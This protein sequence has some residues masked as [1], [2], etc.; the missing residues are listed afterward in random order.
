MTKRCP[1]PVVGKQVQIIN[2]PPPCLTSVCVDMQ[3]LVCSKCSPVCLGQKA[4]LWSHLSSRHS[5]EDCS[6]AL[7]SMLQTSKLPKQLQR[8]QWLVTN[9]HLI[10]STKLLLTLLISMEA[11]MMFFTGLHRVLWK[12][13]FHMTVFICKI[14]KI[15]LHGLAHLIYRGCMNNSE[16]SN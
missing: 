4:L 2:P 9:V 13:C 1:G 11:L 15:N 5:W 7:S 14:Y 3:C 8:C 12:H 6:I 10:S 16:I